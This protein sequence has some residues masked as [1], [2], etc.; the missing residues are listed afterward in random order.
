M[1][2]IIPETVRGPD[3]LRDTEDDAPFT[4]V[5]AALDLLGLNT[6]MAPQLTSRLTV[7]DTTTRIESTGYTDAAKRRITAIVRN[8]SGNPALLERTEEIIP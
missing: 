8:R 4:D 7:N 5:N 6:T 3:G 1:A 2:T